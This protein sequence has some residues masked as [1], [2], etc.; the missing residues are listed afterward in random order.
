MTEEQITTPKTGYDL[1]QGY[2]RSLDA[3]PGV[4]R[5][6]D[7]DS[8]VLYVGKARN[9]KARRLSECPPRF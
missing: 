7:A 8:R 9:L 1:I 4:Y 2:L 3:S 6:L 5:M